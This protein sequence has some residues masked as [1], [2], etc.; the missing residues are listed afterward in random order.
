MESK[1]TSQPTYSIERMTTNI[2][3]G[4]VRCVAYESNV[5]LEWINVL[6]RNHSYSKLRD[7]AIDIVISAFLRIYG[8]CPILFV[9]NNKIKEQNPFS[10]ITDLRS[11]GIYLIG[12]INLTEAMIKQ[13]NTNKEQYRTNGLFSQLKF[14]EEQITN[15]IN[16]Q[17]ERQNFILGSAFTNIRYESTSGLGIVELESLR[18]DTLEI[19][20]FSCI[21]LNTPYHMFRHLLLH[22]RYVKVA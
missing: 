16:N 8:P 2:Y 15:T 14:T 17:S 10:V 11:F 7:A 9:N 21:Y 4:I 3:K 22:I 19:C 6:I 13:R 5:L 20:I 12:L 1:N 18:K